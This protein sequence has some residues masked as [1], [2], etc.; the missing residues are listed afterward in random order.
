MNFVFLGPPGSGKGTQAVRVAKALNAVHISTGDLLREAVKNLT[1]LGK[2]VED[3]MKKGQLVPDEVVI[4]LIGQKISA[5]E[6]GRGFI[7]DGFPRN[8][9][10][11][12]S[13][14]FIFDHQKKKLDKAILLKVNDGEVVKRL[15][16]RWYCPQ[17]NTGYNYP[18][19]MPKHEGVCDKDG[20]K[21]LR[22]ADDEESVVKKR[23]EV[24]KKETL[25]I[26]DFYR[27]ES[28]L[29]EIDGEQNP[30]K[31]FQDILT[32]VKN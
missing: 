13:L 20:G 25:P 24:Y 21:L 30:D 26:E 15:S 10:Q 11:A 12:A 27:K 22:R 18:R 7:L 16:G 1:E 4:S 5:L 2:K 19:N 17:C 28:I 32:A 23:L 3:I 14:K 8:V 6:G 29:K 31:V 9:T